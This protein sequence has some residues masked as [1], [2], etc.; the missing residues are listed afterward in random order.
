M[1]YGWNGILG[2][3][4]TQQQ[5]LEQAMSGQITLPPGVSPQT[6]NSLLAKGVFSPNQFSNT[7]SILQKVSLLF[8]LVF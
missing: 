8:C 4:M 2:M 5:I 3:T 7:P 6:V 1:F